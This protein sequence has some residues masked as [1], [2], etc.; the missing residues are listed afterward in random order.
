MAIR[1]ACNLAEADLA[2]VVS[3]QAGVHGRS[4]AAGAHC[5]YIF[6]QSLDGA[7]RSQL[8]NAIRDCGIMQ[9]EGNP[10]H[11]SADAVR[12]VARSL[13]DFGED[14]TTSEA[15]DPSSLR[16][17]TSGAKHTYY[18]T[19]ENPQGIQPAYMVFVFSGGKQGKNSIQYKYTM[20]VRWN[21]DAYASVVI[22]TEKRE[23]P[24]ISEFR[25][26]W[27][28]FAEECVVEQA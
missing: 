1:A 26:A 28:V 2:N 5:R 24:A 13:E 9:P 16:R 8:E 15:A 4:F 17:Q 22:L 6:K 23:T 25:D 21:S 7:P 10:K 11:M 14:A 12:I 27:R 19:A 18:V 20:S 3:E